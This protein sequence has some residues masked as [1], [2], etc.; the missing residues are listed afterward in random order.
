MFVLLVKK[1][2]NW[3]KKKVGGKYLFIWGLF[4]FAFFVSSFYERKKKI[5]CVYMNIFHQIQVDDKTSTDQN[6]ENTKKKFQ[7]NISQ[8]KKKKTPKKQS[9]R[10]I[11]NLNTHLPHHSAGN[12]SQF[13]WGLLPSNSVF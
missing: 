10:K 12:L 8:L 4:I 11:P 7:R 9:E 3:I 13:T 1:K 6:P 5:V 2:K